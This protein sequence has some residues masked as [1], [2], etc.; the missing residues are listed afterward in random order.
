MPKVKNGGAINVVVPRSDNV[1]R[2]IDIEDDNGEFNKGSIIWRMNNFAEDPRKNN[3][4]ACTGE[5]RKAAL[6]FRLINPNVE[7]FEQSKVNKMVKNVLTHYKDTRYERN[8]Q[9]IFCDLGV[10]KENSQKID[11]NKPTISEFSTIE[12]IAKHYNLEQRP[13]YEEEIDKDGNKTGLKIEIGYEWVQYDKDKK[14]KDE[15]RKIKKVYT[16]EEVLDIFGNNFDVYSD[17]LKKLVK[18]GIPQ[19]QI[20]FIGDAKNDKAKQALFDK[21]ND[22]VIRVL[23]GS[24]EKMGAGTNV[25]QRVVAMHELDCP[26]RPADLE[27]RLGRVVRQGNLFFDL[28]KENFEISHYRYSTE[29]TY[30]ARMFQINEQKLKPLIQIKKSEFLQNQ[31][32]FD[33]IDSELLNISEMKAYATGNPFILE[34]HKIKGFLDRE[35]KAKEYFYKTKANVERE[36]ESAFIEKN[37]LQ[38]KL[39]VLQEML[40]NRGFDKDIYELVLFKGQFTTTNKLATKNEE[41]RKDFEALDNIIAEKTRQF[42]YAPARFTENDTLEYLKANDITLKFKVANNVD[43]S[44]SITGIIE[45]SGGK[46][47]KSSNL[48]YGNNSDNISKN[49]MLYGGILQRLKNLFDKDNIEREIKNTKE[50]IRKNE[51]EIKDK[52]NFLENKTYDRQAILDTLKKDMSNINQIMILRNQFRKEGK[53][54]TM[55]SEEIKDLL[56]TYKALLINE[57]KFVDPKEAEKILKDIADGNYKESKEIQKPEQPVINNE[58]DKENQN[59]LRKLTNIIKDEVI[60]WGKD[61][62]KQE[63]NQQE[64]TA[65]ENADITQNATN[66]LTQKD[67]KE[68]VAITKIRNLK[69]DTQDKQLIIDSIKSGNSQLAKEIYSLDFNQILESPEKLKA[70]TQELIANFELERKAKQET[71]PESNAAAVENPDKQEAKPKIETKEEQKTEITKEVKEESKPKVSSIDEQIAKIEQAT[72]EF[73]GFSNKDSIEERMA[74]LEKNQENIK[75]ATRAKALY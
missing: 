50:S 44:N 64:S 3:I 63:A 4:L 40:A 2:F 5:A 29:Q 70:K 31:R 62:Q 33:G 7:D 71:T 26:W 14:G 28:D 66:P 52:E 47:Y 13:R 69:I 19:N 59:L 72:I 41:A 34:K 38:E 56:P 22:G 60:S 12:D 23:I 16:T 35:E 20:A 75:K 9:L 55:E 1:A 42:Q 17:I 68:V 58:K 32:T 49:P 53:K 15:N 74:I 36:L 43:G 46:Q 51:F 54:I 11:I 61:E 8:T 65:S 37:R 25:Q 30:D 6:D 57:D 39:E 67:K 48:T 45:T 24:T 18:S 10:S 27:Q 73:K 21:V